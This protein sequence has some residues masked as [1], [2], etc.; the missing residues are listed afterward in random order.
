MSSYIHGSTDEAE[1]ARLATQAGF[2]AA[3]SLTNFDAA[4]G[5]HVLDLGTGV[6]AMAAQIFA[7]CPGIRLFGVDHSEA[8]I[9]RARSMHKVAE[10]SVANAE[11]L[12]F[13]AESFDRVHVSWLLEHIPDPK[14]IAREIRRV[15]KPGG[16]AH[17]IEVDNATLRAT[18]ALPELDATFALLNE[19]QKA[20]HG[21]PFIGRKLEGLFVDAEFS[22]VEARSIALHGTSEDPKFYR[23]FAEEFAGICESLDEVLDARDQAVAHAA[24]KTLRARVLVPKTSLSYAPVL[25]RAWR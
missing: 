23:E 10:Y 18:P 24:A 4:P 1:V 17:V 15:L 7:R 22:K 2:V 6:G 16:Y 3:F 8:Q 21:D 14:A 11:Q 12:P 19:A 13:A 9:A 20:R 5:M 25:L